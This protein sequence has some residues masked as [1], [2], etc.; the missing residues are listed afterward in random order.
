[1]KVEN[2]NYVQVHYTGTLEDGSVFDSSEG[3]EPLETLV[4]HQMLIK[5][6]DN[7]LVGME[8]GEE[9]EITIP[10]DEAYGDRHE[11]LIR[12]IPLSELGE[13]IKPEVGMTLGVKSPEGQVFPATVKEVTD[14]KIVLDAN[15]PLAG[16]T[17]KFKLKLVSTRA[18]TDDDKKKFGHE[19]CDHE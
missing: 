19:N 14:E 6:F 5:G 4:G 7:A 15:H 10:K 11:E 8:E 2:G 12:D 1:M 17:L 9:K 13:D 18:A 3:K 16:Q